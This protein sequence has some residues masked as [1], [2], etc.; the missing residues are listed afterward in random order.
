MAPGYASV[1]ELR[2]AISTEMLVAAGL[3]RTGPLQTLLRPLV[4]LPA[5]HFSHLMAD[6]DGRVALSGLTAAVRWL[7]PRFVEDVRAYGQQH[8]PES[9]PLVVA[10]NH[11][12]STDVLAIVSALGRND[13][14]VYVSDVPF[15][16]SLRG[17]SKHLIFIP[18]EPHVRMAAV[19]EGVR[20]LRTGGA[21]LVLATGLVEPDPAVMPGA[22]GALEQWS[23]SLPLFLRTVPEARLLV[24]IVSGVVAPAALR[25]PLTWLRRDPRLKQMLAEF[26]QISQQ[27]LVRRSFGLVPEVRFAPPLAASELSRD[28]NG[29]AALAA[30][31]TRARRLLGEVQ[32][33]RAGGS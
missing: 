1:P 22:E 29:Q 23:A 26:I 15:L 3:P 9:G 30:I 16:R 13:L 2:R 18:S 14:K 12:G 25:H 7:I 32:P 4:W 33:Y 27:M 6:L 17:S 10:S 19:R 21:L 11:P 5:H 8:V 31:T 20:H 28:G 24:T